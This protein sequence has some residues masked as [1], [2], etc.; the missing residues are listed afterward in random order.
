MSRDYTIPTKIYLGNYDT[1]VCPYSGRVTGNT[2][3]TFTIPGWAASKNKITCSYLPSENGPM[4]AAIAAYSAAQAYSST[5][6]WIWGGWA[7]GNA[8]PSVMSVW[9]KL[10]KGKSATDD[11]SICSTDIDPRDFSLTY[12][13][14]VKTF[15]SSM[16]GTIGNLAM[17][18]GVTDLYQ[19]SIASSLVSACVSSGKSSNCDFAD[20]T[21]PLIDTSGCTKDNN[22]DC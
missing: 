21:G 12:T 4:S 17:N 11:S 13:G 7:A 5:Q 15:W 20:I 14:N 22:Q 10:K 16:T 18:I 19:R 2:Y 6:L 1:F 3:Y 9:C 8:V